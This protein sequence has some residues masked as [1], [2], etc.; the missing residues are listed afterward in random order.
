MRFLP[1]AT[2]T[3][4]ALA[5]AVPGAL[6][7]DVTKIGDIQRGSSVSLQGEVTRILDEDEFRLE[8]DTGSVRV[9][10][11]WKNRVMVD[12]GEKVAVNGIVDDD[13]IDFFRPEVYAREIVRQ[14]GTRITLD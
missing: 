7:R 6:A 5:L 2:V 10:I 13:L 1:T 11:G 8:D 3:L 9:Y 12:V 4:L 14:D